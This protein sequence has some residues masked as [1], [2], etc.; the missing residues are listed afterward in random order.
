M[1]EAEPTLLDEHPSLA[2][3]RDEVIHGLRLRQKRLPSKYFYDPRGSE[4]FDRICEQPEY[5]LTRTEI[6]I[7]ET[8]VEEMARHIGPR[9][10]VVEPGSGSG[11]KTRLLLEALEDPVAYVPVE[12]A[13]EHLMNAVQ[14]LQQ[15]WPEIEI[16]PVCADFT[17][18][19]GVPAAG[20]EPARTAVY[21]PGSTIGNFDGDDALALMVNMR[22]VAGPG[23]ALLVGVDLRKERDVLE[24]AYNDA[25]GVTA[26]FNLNLLKRIND[27]LGADFG[28]DG[29]RH[30]AVWNGPKGRIEMHLV[31]ERAQQVRLGTLRFAFRAGEHIL[32]EYSYKYTLDGFAALARRAGFRVAQVWVDP[33]KLFSV[34]YLEVSLPKL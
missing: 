29:F 28:L 4:L 21:F 5:Y 31:S 14:A 8:R 20:R 19:F 12:I 7:L 9:A 24:A 33:Q 30:R 6:G 2:E 1:S 11:T 26:A 15:S 13:R 16:L 18:N 27:E 25:A 32:T 23:G 10:M 34:Q 22:E 3:F 17:A